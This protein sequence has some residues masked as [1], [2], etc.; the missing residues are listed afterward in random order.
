[1]INFE[2][3]AEESHTLHKNA[4]QRLLS[5]SQHENCINWLYVLC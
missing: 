3:L 2:P 1:M 4:W 5:T